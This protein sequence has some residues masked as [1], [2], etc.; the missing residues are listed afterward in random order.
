[1]NKLLLS[2]LVH[3]P[4]IK[5]LM[6]ETA[7]ELYKGLAEGLHAVAGAVVP[8][9]GVGAEGYIVIMTSVRGV[10]EGEDPCGE[11]DSIGEVGR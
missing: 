5:D 8:S 4:P 7:A 6:S 9:C 3:E 10:P 1:M 2:G 11:S